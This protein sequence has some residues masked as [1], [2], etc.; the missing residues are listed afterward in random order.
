MNNK[1][2][3]T[4]A[5][6]F[7][8]TF[9][10]ALFLTILNNSEATQRPPCRVSDRHN[11]LKILKELITWP[12][13]G[14]RKSHTYWGSRDLAFHHIFTFDVDKNSH[15]SCFTIRQTLLL[16]IAWMRS[17][18][19]FSRW[20][21]TKKSKTNRLACHWHQKEADC[22]TNDKNNLLSARKSLYNNTIS[23]ARAIFESRHASQQQKQL[24]SYYAREAQWW[25]T[26]VRMAYNHRTGV[27]RNFGKET[28]ALRSRCPFNRKPCQN[29]RVQHNIYQE[30]LKLI[31]KKI[32]TC[33]SH[34]CTWIS[35]CAQDKHALFYTIGTS[36]Y[37]IGM[38]SA[39][40]PSCMYQQGSYE[41]CF[42]NNKGQLR[43]S[44]Q[45]ME[46]S[47]H[48]CQKLF[49]SPDFDRT[50]KQSIAKI[51]Q[52][53]RKIIQKMKRALQPR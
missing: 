42:T 37:F 18:Y 33:P 52:R 43:I 12:R 1:N 20:M 35:I 39:K 9:S 7:S 2:I 31:R 15:H 11:G 24:A 30:A 45:W 48:Y 6:I 36:A 25:R 26:R 51:N 46:T 41:R 23:Q 3:R 4:I 14:F 27:C 34:G 28:Q 40:T 49:M 44:K 10:L 53:I 21:L 50:G 13:N 38:R 22:L 32:P 29:I 16:R 19:Y 5:R 47:L 8:F 17:S